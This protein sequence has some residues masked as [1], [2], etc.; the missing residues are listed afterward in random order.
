M[1]VYL[2]IETG[3]C[4]KIILE[5]VSLAIKLIKLLPNMIKLSS[6]F[7]RNFFI[8]FFNLL[9]CWRSSTYKPDKMAPTI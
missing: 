2:K 3:I 8:N 4:Y 5:L 6:A 1:K 9:C 7:C